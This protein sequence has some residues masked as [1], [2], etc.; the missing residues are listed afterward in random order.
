M[1]ALAILGDIHSGVWSA[2]YRTDPDADDGM[3]SDFYSPKLQEGSIRPGTAIYDTNGHVGIVYN[4]QADGRIEYMD[5]HP[6][7]S[8]TRSVYGAQFG[9]SPERLGGGLK[10]WRP[11]TGGREISRRALHRRARRSRPQRSDPRFLDGAISR[12]CAGMRG[13]EQRVRFAYNGVELG[14]YEYLR[15]AVSGGKVEYNPVY[16]LRSTMRT[17]C[18]DLEYCALYVDMAVKNGMSR[19]A[20]PARLPDNI[21]NASDEDWNLIDA[22]ARCAAEDRFRAALYGPAEDDLLLAAARSAHRL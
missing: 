5:A 8:V 6:D 2:T 9:Q 16:E 15:V 19:R 10:N 4:V 20:Q 22:V 18:N 7:F 13:D 11:L 14:F 1:P 17:L 12:Q 3:L 21:Y